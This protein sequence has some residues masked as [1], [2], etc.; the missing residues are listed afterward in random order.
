MKQKRNG[1][2][3]VLLV[4]IWSLLGSVHY[5]QAATYTVSNT[6]D[7]GSGSLRQA[8]IDAN[9]TSIADTIVFNIPGDGKKQIIPNSPMPAIT[10]PVTIN[11]TTQTCSSCGANEPR[12][13]LSGNGAG[14]D[15]IGLRITGNGTGSTIRGMI[16]NRFS[17]NGIFLDSGSNTIVGN[18][19]GTNADGTAAAAN[20]GDG[21]GIFSGTNLVDASNNTIGG[22]VAAD[23]NVISGNSQNGIGITA[24]DGGTAS[25]NTI[26]GNYIGTNASGTSAIPNGGDG[27]LINHAQG[28][29]TLSGNTVGGTTGI[30]VGGNCTGA[31]N[32]ISGNSVNGVGLWHGGVT[33]TTILGNYIGTNAGGTSAI[34]NGDI[35]VEIQESANNI[36]GGTSAEARN[37]ISG[38]LGAGVFITGG[39][40]TGNTIHGNYI[41]TNAAGTADVGNVKMGLGIGYS[42]GIQAAHDNNIGSIT[43]TTPGGA[44]TGGCNLISGNDQNGVLIIGPGGN[45]LR[46]NYI[47]TNAAGT[48][49]I[50]NTLDGIGI[51]NSP[52]NGIGNGTASGRNVISA[53]GDNG[54]IITGG[55]G[56]RIDGNYIGLASDGGSLGN[57]GA[58][59]MLA[60]GADTAILGNGINYNVKLGIDLGYNNVSLNDQNDGDGGPNKTQNFPN[61]FGAVTKDISGT[62]TTKI[63]GHFN[64]MPSSSFRLDFFESGNCNAGVPLNFGE[65]HNF[66]G[67]LDVTTDVHGNTAFVFTPSSSVPNGKYI[68]ATATKKIGST[69]A[70]TSE[71]SQC[72]LNNVAKPALTDSATWY[73]KYD[74][75]TGSAD[76]TF[77][78]G[79]P[80]YQLMCAWDPNQLGVKLPVVFSEGSW[81]MRASYTTGT[82]DLSFSYGASDAKPVCGDWDG[83][84]VETIGV[85][86]P[87]STWSLRNT[88]SSGAPDIGPFQYGPFPST[89]VVGDWDGDGDDNIGVFFSNNSWSQRNTNDSGPATSEFNFGFI[90]GYPVVG[91]WDGDGDDTIGSVSD[92]NWALRNSNSSGA[93]N[94]NFQ[95]G[96]PGAKPL[97]W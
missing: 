17:S 38:N 66:I 84:G 34:A 55:T 1:F 6:N 73:L 49:N 40:A 24:Q 65:G 90:P 68:T 80:A 51:D 81:F 82:A 35:G 50:K 18:Y 46:S 31:C 72:I 21:I 89:P 26:T 79:F 12:I 3:S 91:D 44:C 63:G 78:Y 48:G 10:Q 4:L 2:I 15:A 43:G 74:L 8:I 60:G 52:N 70:E 33:S 77:G 86:S 93:A 11:G 39:S 88:N 56:N 19:I 71:F 7:S 57:A 20:G 67:S 61:L 95:Y 76:K 96:F 58:G 25:S 23:R 5:V 64:S 69:P 16:I 13:E 14:N 29:G 45:Q 32:L 28:S 41:G 59:V 37:V 75:T 94:V 47:G 97:I 54:I 9:A 30:T 53:N 92:S 83:D 27:I 87:N 36:V 42:P 85:V 62:V 22:T